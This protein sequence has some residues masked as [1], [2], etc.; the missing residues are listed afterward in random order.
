M[1]DLVCAKSTAEIIKKYGFSIQ[2]KFGQN[3]LIDEHVLDKII[4]AAQID[5]TYGVIEIGPGLGTMTRRLAALS[6][7]V[8]AIEIDR[9]LIPILS[10]T[11]S[12]CDNVKVINADVMKT[13]LGELIDEEFKDMPVKVVANLPYYITTP[14]VMSLLEGRFAIESITIM[15][16]KEVAERMRA[17]PGSKDYGALSLAVGYY[18]DAYIAANVPP[19]CFMPRPK[20]GS[21][22]IRLNVRKEPDVSVKDEKQMFALIRGAF[23]QRRKTLV[24]AVANYEG[25]SFKKEEI[26]EALKKLDLSPSIRGEALDL[27]QFAALS[28]ILT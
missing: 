25:L 16:Q 15:I 19:N 2:K 12:D 9:Q 11:L 3:F 1:S 6:K 5:T 10:D 21:C 23:N 22:V 14:I 7:K 26:E 27:R 28:D 8:V 13:D 17:V 24:N 4:D 20:V 18:A